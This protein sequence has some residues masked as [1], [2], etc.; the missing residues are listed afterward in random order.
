MTVHEKGK[1]FQ[2]VVQYLGRQGAAYPPLKGD[3]SRDRLISMGMSLQPKRN[4]VN[5]PNMPPL[6]VCKYC[7]SQKVV[8]FGKWK[9]GLR[10][11][12]C[13]DCHHTFIHDYEYPIIKTSA[14]H[15]ASYADL[16]Y[17]GTPLDGL[18]EKFKREHNDWEVDDNILWNWVK[19]FTKEAIIRT[20]DFRPE[21]G[22]EWT[23]DETSL[24][25]KDKIV[26]FWDIIDRKT[27]YLL[28]THISF[29]PRSND[30]KEL[31]EAARDR[32][33]KN[34]KLIIS[35]QL[36]PYATVFEGVAGADIQLKQGDPPKSTSEIEGLHKTLEQRNE[37]CGK[38]KF[39]RDIKLLTD[40]WSV[41][42]NF[43]KKNETVGDVPPVQTMNKIVPLKDWDDLVNVLD[44]RLKRNTRKTFPSTI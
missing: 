33:S 22:D 16:Y 38:F 10:I 32:A 7:E 8:R 34:P 31:I 37:I 17:R 20:K 13:R 2:K 30:V 35:D 12:M 11:Y 23:A 1:V 40:G 9:R 44:K 21:V 26:Y 3:I 39:L 27:R 41:Y 4:P 6:V 15:M 24:K 18:Q 14:K 28:A 25:L 29:D 43:I 36:L 19:R 5:P 42:Y